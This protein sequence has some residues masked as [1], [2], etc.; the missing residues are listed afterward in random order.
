MAQLSH[1]PEGWD[2]VVSLLLYINRNYLSILLLMIMIN[3]RSI[4]SIIL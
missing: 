3:N 2:D 1:D 4:I